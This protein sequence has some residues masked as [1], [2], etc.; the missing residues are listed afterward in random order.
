M[1]NNK[2]IISKQLITVGIWKFSFVGNL[3]EEILFSPW[4]LLYYMWQQL[5]IIKNIRL[6]KCWGIKAVFHW[7][8]FCPLRFLCW[9]FKKKLFLQYQTNSGEHSSESVISAFLKSHFLLIDVFLGIFCLFLG[10]SSWYSFV[11]M[12]IFTFLIGLDLFQ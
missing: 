4:V 3:I 6:S 5:N 11:L 12:M 2:S 7:V 8:S 10:G 1:V 9:I